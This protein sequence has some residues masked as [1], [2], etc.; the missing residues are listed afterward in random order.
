MITRW[1]LIRNMTAEEAAVYLSLMTL[2]FKSEPVMRDLLLKPL[3]D[4]EYD[5]FLDQAR[6]DPS[7]PLRK[8]FKRERPELTKDWE[9]AD[10]NR[11][12][13]YE[14]TKRGLPY[15]YDE[16]GYVIRKE[17]KEWKLG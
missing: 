8:L 14:L 1:E 5:M 6:L 3:N 7:H 4:G 13:I 15:E 12:R 9:K 16:N 2:E 17:N 11:R 10:E